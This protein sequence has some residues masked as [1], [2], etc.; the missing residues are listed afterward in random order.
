MFFLVSSG[1]A[2]GRWETLQGLDIQ[3]LRRGYMYVPCQNNTT[4]AFRTLTLVSIFLV[5]IHAMLALF[6]TKQ[7]RKDSANGQ[8][9]SQ[10]TQFAPF[11]FSS[12]TISFNFRLF[13]NYFPLPKTGLE[14]WSDPGNRQDGFINWQVNGQQTSSLY[15]PAV[16]PD[17]GTGGTKELSSAR[18]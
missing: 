4:W 17:Q 13:P 9:V 15:A 8:V 5:T 6:L 2:H 14:Y 10:S 1:L 18:S 7:T 3:R 11:S 12:L 16:G